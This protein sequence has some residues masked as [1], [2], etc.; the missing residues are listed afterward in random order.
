MAIGDRR[1]PRQRK[2][3]VRVVTVVGLEVARAIRLTDVPDAGCGSAPA[4]WGGVPAS[5]SN[6]LA[7]H[8]P[9]RT[10]ANTGTCDSHLACKS[11]RAVASAWIESSRLAWHCLCD[12]SSSRTCCPKLLAIYLMPPVRLVLSFAERKRSWPKILPIGEARPSP[13][14]IHDISHHNRSQTPMDARRESRGPAGPGAPPSLVCRSASY[15]SYPR[16]K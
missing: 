6:G 16:L 9:Q 10:F 7:H 4:T 3:P 11:S 2:V 15:I 13:G 5:E 1:A 12:L 14:H 8:R